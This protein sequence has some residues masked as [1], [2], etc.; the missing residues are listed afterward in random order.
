TRWNLSEVTSPCQCDWAT[1][2]ILKALILPVLGTCGPMHRSSQFLSFWPV[3][4]HDKVGAPPSKARFALSTLYLL[5]S[6]LRRATPLAGSRSYLVN[7]RS[8]LTISAIC[9]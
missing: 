2:M 8:S 7:G 3:T 9:F 1:D 6:L 4:Y 5:P